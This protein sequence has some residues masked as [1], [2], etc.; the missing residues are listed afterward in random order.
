MITHSFLDTIFIKKRTHDPFLADIP[1]QVPP[2]TPGTNKTMAEALKASFASWEKEQLRLN[3]TK[4]TP[5]ENLVKVTLTLINDKLGIKCTEDDLNDVYRLGRPNSSKPRTVIVKFISFLKKSA[6]YKSKSLLKNTGIYINEDLRKPKYEAFKSTR[7]RYGVKNVWTINDRQNKSYSSAWVNRVSVR[8]NFTQTILDHEKSQQHIS[9]S[10]FYNN[11]LQ[12]NTIDT[13]LKSEIDSKITFWRDVL[14][15]I[16]NVII[17]LVSCNLPLRGHDSDSGDFMAISRLL[18]NY[19]ATLKELLLKP[20]E[21]KKAALLTI[22]LDTTQ[23]LSKIDQLSVVF[24]YISVTENDDNVP[25]EIKIC[26]SFL[27]FIAVTDC[28]AV[29]LKT[30]ILNLTKEYLIDLT[31]CRGQGY[32]G[33]NVLSVVYGGLQTLIKEHAPNVHCAAHALNLV[34]NDAARHVR[35]WA[36]KEFSLDCI[37]LNQFRMKG[38]D[39]CAMGKDA[40]SARAPAFVGDILWEH[41]ELLQKDVEKERALSTTTLSNNMYEQMCVPELDPFIDYTHAHSVLSSEDRKPLTT[42]PSPT[43]NNFLHEGKFIRIVISVLYLPR[44]ISY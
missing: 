13:L 5:Q 33:T 4:E 27:G 16:I 14:H 10:L 40:F 20:K 19:D 30:V 1:T 21:I 35:E 41:L 6:I 24:R 42:N 7:I 2:L 34:L 9:A 44:P 43:N 38:K 28:S 18:S 29:G 22:I 39:I 25:K 8:S 11:W 17:T 12:G 15:R 31:K 36:A 32:D 37:P 3:I 26:E 23:D